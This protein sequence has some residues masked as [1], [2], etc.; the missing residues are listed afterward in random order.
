MQAR[1]TARPR[2]AHN[3]TLLD[4]GTLYVGRFTG[5]S[6]VAE[7]DGTGKLPADGK[8]DGSGEWIPLASG[9]EVVRARHDRRGGVRL[10]AP[11]RRTRSARRRWTARR[12]SRPPDAPA[13]STARSSNNVDRG[14]SAGKEGATEPNPRVNNKHGQVLEIVERRGD[15]L[16]LTFTWKLFLVCG[17]PD[18]AGHLLRRLRQVAGQPDLQPGQRGVRPARQPVDLHRRPTRSTDS[19]TACTACRWRAASAA[20][21]SCSSRCRAARRPAVR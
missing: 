15:A 5:D 20:T 3:M 21:S 14:V 17:D 4:D 10:H 13:R 6:P 8:F 2:A 16:A 9:Q 18:V 7:I 19:T 11:R 12:T 1:A